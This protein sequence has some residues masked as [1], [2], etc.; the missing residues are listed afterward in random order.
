MLFFI[1][2]KLLSNG[3]SKID[4]FVFIFFSLLTLLRVIPVSGRLLEVM[5]YI[6]LA[7]SLASQTC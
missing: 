5:S 4:F 6:C 2:A 1:L 3:E 7:V